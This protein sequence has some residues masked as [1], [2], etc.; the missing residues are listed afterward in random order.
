MAAAADIAKVILRYRDY[1]A[2][3]TGFLFDQQARWRMNQPTQF[4]PA[5]VEAEQYITRR[6]V[7]FLDRESRVHE[8][9][10]GMVWENLCLLASLKMCRLGTH[11]AV[12]LPG[13]A[14]W[15]R[16][17]GLKWRWLVWQQLSPYDDVL[18]ACGLAKG[19]EEAVAAMKAAA[20][21]CVGG[22]GG[23]DGNRYESSNAVAKVGE[24]WR[25][26]LPAPRKGGFGGTTGG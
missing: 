2:D 5:E 20:E 21:A 4:S 10:R 12:A 24:G 1:F 25:R 15:H 8:H 19:S 23:V 11:V 3:R 22:G 7:G 16:W 6:I 14:A 26:R 9:S 17:R 13:V 18:V